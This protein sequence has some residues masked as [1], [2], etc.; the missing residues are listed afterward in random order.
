[1]RHFSSGSLGSIAALFFGASLF[2]VAN[3]AIPKLSVS[4]VV[5]LL[6]QPIQIRVSG[7]KHD[8]VADLMLRR[9]DAKGN[10]TSSVRC[11]ANSSGAIDLAT[12]LPLAGTY[13]GADA[14]GLFWSLHPPAGLSG[15][16]LGPRPDTYRYMLQLRANGRTLAQTQ[17]TRT[18][19][20]PLVQEIAL[21]TT[22]IGKA[23]A[24]TAVG[25]HPA[26]L[27]VGGS[28]GGH[29][30][31]TFAQVLAA[32]GFVCLSLAYFAESTLPKQLVDVPLET[33]QSGL[34]WLTARPDVDGA[35]IGMMGVSKGGELTLLSASM[36]PQIKA[37]VALVPSSVVWMGITQSPGPQ[38]SSWTYHGAPLDFV[39]GDP[40]AGM[41]LG[42]QFAKHQPISL[43]PMYSE[44]LQNTAAANKAAIAVEQING[45]V[46]LVSGDSDAMWPSSPMSDAVMARLAVHHHPFADQHLHYKN[47]GHTAFFPYGPAYG[48]TQDKQPWGGFNFGGSDSGDARAAEDAWP[49]IVRFLDTALANKAAVR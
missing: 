38:P 43:E 5:A 33:V 6:D 19:Q 2:G 20:S 49:K 31:D 29:S 21:P 16:I 40:K 12:C 23:F 44:S 32:R 11:R 46:L 17:L 37:A 41:A 7:L 47:A 45:P 22:L 36:F 25:K 3:A 18:A 26:I 8:Q 9:V 27:I 24:P 39:P 1:M 30:L 13:S 10:W 14:M 4:P 48:M 15:S 28:E 35:H 42:M 34:A